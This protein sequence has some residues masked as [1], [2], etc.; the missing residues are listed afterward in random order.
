MK[1]SP[2]AM[3]APRRQ[4]G[5]SLIEVLVSI[6]V[7]SLGLLGAVALQA[8]ALRNNQGSY[9]RTQTAI[10]T[11]GI[12]DA[13]RANITGI[14]SYNT[15]GMICV[16]PAAADLATRR[17]G[18]LDHQPACA[19]PP[20]RLRCRGLQRQ[21]LHGAGAVGRL[22][23]LGRPGRPEHQPDGPAMNK[24]TPIRPGRPTG[25]RPRGTDDLAGAGHD[26]GR[27]RPG[28]AAVH[29]AGH[30]QHRKP[31]PRAGLGAH[32]L[33]D[34]DARSAGR[35][36]HSLRLQGSGQQ[37]AEQRARRSTPPGGPPGTSL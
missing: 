2:N 3:P 13:M 28:A 5:V 37:R 21:R 27:R 29:A 7:V 34:D 25:L 16:A 23:R 14:A 10:L 11:Q 19:D 18:A 6:L 36:R 24:R 8:T 15:G 20:R 35:R 4:R 32:E 1:S 12:F 30:R 33:R 22:P 26:R 9:E 31:L 17:P